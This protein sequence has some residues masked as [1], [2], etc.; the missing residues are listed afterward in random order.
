[1]QT[2][3]SAQALEICLHSAD[4][5]YTVIRSTR[6]SSSVRFGL[7]DQGKAPTVCL[8]TKRFRI[9]VHDIEDLL[10]MTPFLHHLSMP[11]TLR[12]KIRCCFSNLVI[13]YHYLN[14]LKVLR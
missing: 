10:L 3:E 14:L 7:C 9:T 2:V 12:F 8:L 11:F 1:M 4:T 5:H 13:S 6:I